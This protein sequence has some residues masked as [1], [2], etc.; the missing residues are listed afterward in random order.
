MLDN[1]LILLF[2]FLY[3]YKDH[4]IITVIVISQYLITTTVLSTVSYNRYPDETKSIIPTCMI[5]V[6]FPADVDIR[7]I[8]VRYKQDDI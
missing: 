6:M 4:I 3:H 2:F 1:I 7:H 8:I 5:I